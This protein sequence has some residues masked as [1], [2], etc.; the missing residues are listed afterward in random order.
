MI[1]V[2]AAFGIVSKM[3]GSQMGWFVDG[4]ST[5]PQSTISLSALLTHSVRLLSALLVNLQ[6]NAYSHLIYALYV[7]ITLSS[8]VQDPSL[9]I[10]ITLKP[11][12]AALM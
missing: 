8:S 2:V 6:F 3:D 1:K 5:L 9:R 7:A 11:V 4:W 12:L 10:L